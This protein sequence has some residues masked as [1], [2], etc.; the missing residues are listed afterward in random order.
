MTSGQSKRKR[1]VVLTPTGRQKL[2]EAI[3]AWEEQDNFGEKLT[4]EELSDRTKLDA[5]TVAKVLD[6]EEGVDRRTLERFFQAFGLALSEKDYS[7]PTSSVDKRPAKE[8]R[9]DWGEAVDASI[10]YGRTS[11]LETLG[12]WIVSDRCRLVTLL[13]MGG[14]GKTSLAAKLGEKVQ[15]EFDYVV[16]R[17]L[18]EAP[19]L[20]EILTSLVQFLSNQQETEA[21]LPESLGGRITKLL[22]YLR[23]HR[24]L[25]VLDNAESILREG[26]A[27]VYREGYEGYGELLRRV[28]ESSHQ[29]CLLI[30]SREKARE[31]SAMEGEAFLVRSLQLRGVDNA[32]GQEI[33]KAKGLYLSKTNT[34]EELIHR[35]AGNPLALKLVATT[36]QDLFDGDIAEFLN[37]G[38]I[39]FEGVRDL[40][41]QHFD[42]LSELEKSVIYW[43]A[44]NREPVSVLEL[45]EDVVPPV[46]KSNLL[47]AL[48]GLVGRSLVEKGTLGFTLQNVVME[49]A[50]NQFVEQ[51]I[52]EIESESFNFFESHAL[53][54]ATAKDY[55]RSNQTR[56]ILEQITESRIFNTLKSHI[57]EWSSRILFKIKHQYSSLAGYSVGNILNILVSLGKDLSRYDF[58]NLTIKQAYLQGISLHGVNLSYSEISK[59]VFSQTFGAIRSVVF[60][61]DA[62][63]IAA[64]DSNGYIRI[65]K[66]IDYKEILNFKGHAIWVWSVT[67]SPDG[68]ILASGSGDRTIKL[69]D[70]KTGQCIKTFLGHT[71]SVRSLTFSPDGKILASSSHDCTIRLWDIQAGKCLRVLEGQTDWVWTVTFSFD[72]KILA[73]GSLD[74][75]IW[76]WDTNTGQ[77]FTTFIGHSDAVRSI[78]FCPNNAN[79][80]AS[81]SD[82]Q[83][84]RLWDISTGECLKILK[85]HDDQVLTVLFS[86]NSRMLAS[87]SSD[88]TIKLWNVNTGQC[89]RTLQGHTQWIESIAFSPDDQLLAS[90]G[91]DRTVR[92][93]N[94]ETGYCLKKLVGYSS[95]ITSV[96]FSPDATMIASGSDDNAIRLWDAQTGQCL[97]TL[98]NDAY[99]VWSVS[100][101]PD[102]SILAG[103]GGDRAVRLWDIS[104]GHCIKTLWENDGQV[105]SIRFCPDGSILATGSYDRTI[106]LWDV[107]KGEI[108]N[109]LWGHTHSIQSIDFSPCGKMLVS[110]GN[111]CVLRIWDITTGS[112]IQV[113]QGHTDHVY[114]TVFSPNGH[115][116]A[117]GSHDRTVKLWDARTGTCLATL[118]GHLDTVQEVLFSVDGEVVISC[119]GDKTIKLWNTNTGMCLKTLRGHLGTVWSIASNPDSTTLASASQDESIRIWDLNTGECLKILKALR[120][121]EGMNIMGVT[122][123]TEAQRASLMALGAVDLE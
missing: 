38:T 46:T 98:W 27:G 114:S 70:T 59:S 18:R 6:C 7:R 96:A 85:G 16:W 49:Y 81:S 29:S 56:L 103:S 95:S 10:F 14:I 107:Q 106:K 19:P 84:I 88:Q 20:K 52:R 64:G 113:M 80:L 101:S 109:I 68:S 23:S 75:T 116:I 31:L 110:C 72:G 76:L 69:W 54:K 43:L 89:L 87:S 13:G 112:C 25:V 8:T 28:G 26:Q 33:L 120:P 115:I 35:C 104:T 62:E 48:K 32:D 67:F 57:D 58:S 24:C 11:E 121:Y 93:W 60:S 86:H 79:L 42:R 71:N 83:T 61:R 30:T 55:V 92:I 37:Q 105:H 51:V 97:K 9:I 12:K 118:Q 91:Y 111:D 44:I 36:I 122:G 100:F 34:G 74:H 119:G 2:Q 78:C 5:G 17:S 102:S 47:E 39:A 94:I 41:E 45:Q 65:W 82:D 15:K 90:G 4:I 123:L 99:R 117:S 50:T 108:L 1:G 3:T 22:D 53:I 73:S 21:D 63:L 40:L 77:H 66:A